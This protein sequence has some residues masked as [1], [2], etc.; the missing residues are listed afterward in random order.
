MEISKS[1]LRLH[2][3]AHIR[4]HAHP[5]VICNIL[6]ILYYYNIILYNILYYII[7]RF[8]YIN[9]SNTRATLDDSV[10]DNDFDNFVITPEYIYTYDYEYD[11]KR[12]NNSNGV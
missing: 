8:L 11:Y 2:A 1:F 5:P 9:N 12:D 4:T 10:L 3:Y 6:Y 7:I